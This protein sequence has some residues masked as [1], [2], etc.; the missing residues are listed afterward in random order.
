MVLPIHEMHCKL[1]IRRRADYIRYQHYQGILVTQIKG[2]EF[3]IDAPFA[4]HTSGWA[5]GL[6]A[7]GLDQ[8]V[9]SRSPFEI[10]KSVTNWNSDCPI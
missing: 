1:T 9:G 5:R 8:N 3:H 4:T 7:D 2:A 10:Y 6:V